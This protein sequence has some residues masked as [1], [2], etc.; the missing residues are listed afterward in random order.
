MTVYCI[1]LCSY[2]QCVRFLFSFHSEFKTRNLFVLIGRNVCGSKIVARSK[3]DLV[4]TPR[5]ICKI[6]V[7]KKN[8]STIYTSVYKINDVIYPAIY[9]MY[10]N[11]FLTA[12]EKFDDQTRNRS[13]G[14]TG[15]C[16]ITISSLKATINHCVRS[17]F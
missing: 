15:K 14:W 8:T 16:R 10:Y 12:M 2:I 11:F 1:V 17:R 13:P 9:Y 4:R 6:S 5:R 3:I 7:F